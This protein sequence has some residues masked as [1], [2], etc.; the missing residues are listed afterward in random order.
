MKDT[1]S[2]FRLI[3]VESEIHKLCAQVK[4]VTGSKILRILKA[5]RLASEIPEDLYHLIKKALAI[6]KS[7]VKDVA[8]GEEEANGL[9]R[10]ER[11]TGGGRDADRRSFSGKV[12]G[13]I[14][15]HK[16]GEAKS[17]KTQQPGI[18]IG[19]WNLGCLSSVACVWLFLESKK[20]LGNFLTSQTAE[21]SLKKQAQKTRVSDNYP[22]W[23]SSLE[24]SGSN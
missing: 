14:R 21:D 20:D 1:D 11:E 15:N 24:T 9:E 18:E 13:V 12:A 6:Q 7:E 17:E 19:I 16:D 5:H 23:L 4:S 22:I 8:G 2:I 10:R 3:L